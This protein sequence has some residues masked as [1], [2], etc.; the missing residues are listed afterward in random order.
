MD[1]LILQPDESIILEPGEGIHAG[2]ASLRIRFGEREPGPNMF[3]NAEQMLWSSMK[4]ASG[5]QVAV[6]RRGSESRLVCV[7]PETARS[8]PFGY[9][10][11]VLST[12]SR[13]FKIGRSDLADWFPPE[14]GDTLEYNDGKGTKIY[15]VKL[16]GNAGGTFFQN[17]G[18]GMVMVRIHVTEY[19]E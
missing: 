18:S 12:T 4:Q 6:Y 14:D 8:D 19:I 15:E 11:R 16:T 1:E 13:L 9:D 7:V 17:V 3:D 10:E 2:E 5:N